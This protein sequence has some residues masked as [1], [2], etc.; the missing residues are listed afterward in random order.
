MLR[1]RKGGVIADAPVGDVSASNHKGSL[2]VGTKMTVGPKT[3]VVEPVAF[4][5][6]PGLPGRDLAEAV[7][8]FANLKKGRELT[9]HF[10][11]ALATAGAHVDA[12]GDDGA[13][14]DPKPT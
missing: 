6:S 8:V 5:I 1:K 7:R 4:R 11:T 2:G 10:L 12:A 9:K 13:T 14:D 3:Y